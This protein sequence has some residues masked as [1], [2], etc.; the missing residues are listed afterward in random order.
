MPWQ[1]N[2]AEGMFSSSTFRECESCVCV[3]EWNW[4]R[5]LWHAFYALLSDAEL[6][7]RAA[8]NLNHSE[9]SFLNCYCIWN[10]DAIYLPH[11]LFSAYVVL[12]NNQ[13]LLKSM[14]FMICLSSSLNAWGGILD[15]ISP[16][17]S[18]KEGLS[19][20]KTQFPLV[21]FNNNIYHSQ[22]SILSLF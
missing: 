5:T 15:F 11:S 12:K 14:Y 4:Q 9:C 19:G 7:L 20:L 13:G 18:F 3:R 22:R 1:H 6:S 16:W 10:F 2:G 17:P 21:H 8:E